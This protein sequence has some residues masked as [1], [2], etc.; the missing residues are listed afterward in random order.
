MTEQGTIRWKDQKWPATTLGASEFQRT[1]GRR[2][3]WLGDI[4]EVWGAWCRGEEPGMTVTTSGTTGSSR[5]IRHS[6][7][8]VLSSVKDTLDHWWL[9]PGSKAVLAL[10]T[11]FVAG[12]AMLIRAIEGAW[13]LTLLQ[14]TSQPKWSGAMDF[15][16][17]TPHQAAG[18]LLHGT[19]S[20]RML[21]LGG[22][23]VSSQLV[24]DLLA[25]GRVEE[26]WES[27]GLSETITHVATRRLLDPK[28]VRSPFVPLPGSTVRVDDAG[29]A[30][31]HSPQRNVE[32]LITNDCIAEV[33]G[34]GFVWLGRADDVVN[35]GGVLVHP[36]EV[37]RAFES[38]LPSWV[39]DWVAYGR[40]DDEL[41]EAVVLRIH[42]HPPEPWNPEMQ[43]EEWRNELKILL[44][45]AKTPRALE[46]A[47]VPR[48]ERGKLNRRH[49]QS[50]TPS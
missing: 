32:N 42:G 35:T 24:E 5:T 9:P 31:I 25:S 41:G 12:Q 30:L 14:P 11:S 38:I 22:G 20:C 10:P 49:F 37:E 45:P 50:P 29:C 13:D 8:A 18:W 48:T 3:P 40:V 26:I 44:G 27:F 1:Q 19:G 15:V 17:L 36:N 34:G 28:D 33:P 39:S 2:E 23:P 16:P 47:E 43:L 6:R 4:A 7:A 46:W 21:L